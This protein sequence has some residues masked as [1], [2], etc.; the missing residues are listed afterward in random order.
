MLQIQQV[1]SLLE[2]PGPD[3]QEILLKAM[4]EHCRKWDKIYNFNARDLYPE[5]AD[6]FKKYDY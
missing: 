6:I 1:I 2:R 4:V 3:G 5:L